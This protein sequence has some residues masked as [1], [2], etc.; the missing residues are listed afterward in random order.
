MNAVQERDGQGALKALY[1]RGIEMG[2]GISGLLA[3]VF[4]VGTSFMHY[5]GRGNVVQLTDASGAVSGKYTYDA[6]GNTLSQTGGAAGLNPYRFSTKEVVGS[7]VYYGFRFYSPGMGKWIN[8]DPIEEQGGV[9][10]YGFV[11]NNPIGSVDP[12]GQVV[13]NIISAGVGL[14]TNLGTYLAIGAFTGG[15]TPEGAISAAMTGFVTGLLGPLA[16]TPV[17]AAI[18]GA[19]G[20]VTQLIMEHLL[21]GTLHC[22][23]WGQVIFAAILGALGGR[24]A[25]KWTKGTRPEV[26][27]S[28][29]KAEWLASA[30]NFIKQI[31]AG[32]TLFTNTLKE[33]FGAKSTVL[34]TFGSGV[35]NF[36]NQG[37]PNPERC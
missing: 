28:G 36:P 3:R 35:G 9:N 29:F 31:D 24:I 21:K 1:I 26:T 22:V 13:F 20:A 33:N 27:P 10:Q 34:R 37:S 23:S 11:L 6:F 4:D 12:H 5:D 30:H 15:I 17:G 19:L 7:L 8:K 2:G 18:L 25:N 32:F 14:V 16:L